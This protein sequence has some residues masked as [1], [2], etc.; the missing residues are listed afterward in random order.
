M[1]T[2]EQFLYESTGVETFFTDGLDPEP[3]SRR[4]FAFHRPETLAQWASEAR[5]LRRVCATCRRR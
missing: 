4:T 1:P 5:S 3:R 2:P